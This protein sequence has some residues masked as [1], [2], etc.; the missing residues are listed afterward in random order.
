MF[1]IDEH[2]LPDWREDGYLYSHMIQDEQNTDGRPSSMPGCYLRA[3]AGAPSAL[4]G[5]LTGRPVPL[6]LQVPADADED[7]PVL[8][9]A[10]S[11][12]MEWGSVAEVPELQRRAIRIT[13]FSELDGEA[14]DSEA[15]GAGMW[16][17]QYLKSPLSSPKY[18]T[19]T[20]IALEDLH[21]PSLQAT[22]QHVPPSPN[23]SYID[24]AWRSDGSDASAGEEYD[25]YD[26]Y[27]DE[28]EQAYNEYNEGSSPAGHEHRHGYDE[29]QAR[30]SRMGDAE[31]AAPVA[32][33]P[34]DTDA[35]YHSEAHAGEFD[36]EEFDEYTL[37]A[38][39]AAAAQPPQPPS[40]T[41]PPPPS[42]DASSGSAPRSEDQHDAASTPQ[43]FQRSSGSA[44]A[45]ASQASSPRSADDMNQTYIGWQPQLS[46]PTAA[47]A[48]VVARMDSP[49]PAPA[50]TLVPESAASPVRS[51]SGGAASPAAWPDHKPSRPPPATPSDAV[52]LRAPGLVHR[53]LL[54]AASVAAEEQQPEPGPAATREHQPML[55]TEQR[56]YAASR[57][58][59]MQSLNDALAGV[60]AVQHRQ[61]PRSTPSSASGQ[62]DSPGYDEMFA[63][64]TGSME[65]AQQTQHSS[66]SASSAPEPAAA[67]VLAPSPKA[68]RPVP[69]QAA[70]QL[71]RLQ[72]S[73][74]GGPAR[75][76]LPAAQEASP[77]RPVL[78]SAVA[79]GTHI[80]PT[81]ARRGAKLEHADVYHDVPPVDPVEE[82][83][84]AAAPSQPSFKSAMPRPTLTTAGATAA[85]LLPRTRPA[86][87]TPR[88]VEQR[89]QG[90]QL[91]TSMQPGLP[92][93]GS[94]AAQV[95]DEPVERTSHPAWPSHDTQ[96]AVLP[97]RAAPGWPVDQP[98]PLAPEEELGRER[99]RHH[100]KSKKAKKAKK[101]K[102]HK[103]RSAS[104]EPSV[105]MPAYPGYPHG[106]PA[107]PGMWPGGYHPAVMMP[108][109]F[110]PGGMSMN[111]GMAPVAGPSKSYV[112]GADYGVNLSHAVP[113]GT[114]PDAP[115]PG[116]TMMAMSP[117]GTTMAPIQPMYDAQQGAWVYRAQG[118][119]APPAPAAAS[120]HSAAGAAAMVP[121]AP[122]ARTPEFH[123]GPHADFGSA[124]QG[125]SAFDSMT[126][127]YRAPEPA[128]APAPAQADGT[129][130][131]AYMQALHAGADAGAP[132][133]VDHQGT[134]GAGDET[135][136]DHQHG[137]A[138]SVPASA[139]APAAPAPVAHKP[140][141]ASTRQSLPRAQAA[142]WDRVPGA[143][144]EALLA[145]VRGWQCRSLFAS[146]KV[147]NI[148]R[149]LAD[150]QDMLDD[151]EPA[152]P[153]CAQLQAQLDS[154]AAALVA[155]VCFTSD[156]EMG[157]EWARW[158]ASSRQAKPSTGTRSAPPKKRQ[159]LKRGGG[160]A[161]GSRAAEY[162]KRVRQRNKAQV[163]ED[164]VADSASAKPDSRKSALPPKP[165]QTKRK[166]GQKQGDSVVAGTRQ[167]GSE[168]PP[169]PRWRVV[170]Q[171][172]K[173]EG[174][175][176]G[177]L[178]PG[179][180]AA[181]PGMVKDELS[182]AAAASASKDPSARDAFI[183]AYLAVTTWKP[184]QAGDDAAELLE[185]YGGS[186]SAA[187]ARVLGKKR[188][189][190]VVP[191]TRSP[192]FGE[193]FV[194]AVPS[195]LAD[196]AEDAVRAQR[197][198]PPL[199]DAVGTDAS[200]SRGL[201]SDFDWAGAA[202]RL[203]VLDSDRFVR[204]TFMGW[205]ALPLR[206]AMF[207]KPQ[208]SGAD[209]DDADV[210][211][212]P[213]FAK[214]GKM[215]LPLRGREGR[216]D[217]VAGQVLV[218][219]RMLPPDVQKLETAREAQRA[220]QAAR[221]A[222]VQPEAAEPAPSQPASRAT[223]A[224]R[225]KSAARGQPSFGAAA[226]KSTQRRPY[227]PPQFAKLD[228]SHVKPKTQSNSAA[229]ALSPK[230]AARARAAAGPPPRSEHK[231]RARAPADR[232]SM[233]ADGS[234]RRRPGPVGIPTRRASTGNTRVGAH[235]RPGPRSHL[236]AAFGSAQAEEYRPDARAEQDYWISAAGAMQGVM[237]VDEPSAA[238]LHT[239]RAPGAEAFRAPPPPPMPNNVDLS[240]QGW[241]GAD[242][243]AGQPSPHPASAEVIGDAELMAVLAGM[244]PPQPLSR[245]AIDAE[246]ARFAFDLKERIQ[247][248]SL[249][250]R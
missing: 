140:T 1:V 224:S 94:K 79:T 250:G 142:A 239:P 53:D 16:L 184:R 177:A 5:Y 204:D 119:R 117:G 86:L 216:A 113:A 168:L 2:W 87:D 195:G 138:W 179:V 98:A 75:P 124:S 42:A 160:G 178:A 64:L 44:S 233:G 230:Q 4:R 58:S 226:P 101:A 111:P 164:T 121:A 215:W 246:A 228:W 162:G 19:G 69:R 56:A 127:G 35:S 247:R 116:A 218:K 108:G 38:S 232:H 188:D 17:V 205:A 174:L 171:I 244:Q 112:V 156:A 198:M 208:S 81:P 146:P 165:W 166:P 211:D 13:Q 194:F 48:S 89:A 151:L 150:T 59:D 201:F 222:E 110:G 115:A 219:Y 9:H 185:L 236:A 10:I 159:P 123:S 103:R 114:M 167:L 128:P 182:A 153:L 243:L 157:E 70:A 34:E 155:A 231:P 170:V 27:D 91:A 176:A 135:Y 206:D 212:P 229:P 3:H 65:Y 131:L 163:S 49:S 109:M 221:A 189:T 11:V 82:P 122:E 105:H 147:A 242:V 183:T 139:P 57:V 199:A 214:Q 235:E 95:P 193:Q 134:A 41:P 100:Q 129:D 92:S 46:P 144:R 23:V 96:P 97:A 175:A 62:P 238:D 149:Q 136:A 120:G 14:S 141:A 223:S 225:A 21:M 227:K 210:I 126:S 72:L 7:Q 6:G 90:A 73:S 158:H 78:S 248:E 67:P 249:H 28:A 137:L 68:A 12:Y 50:R 169:A 207:G 83:A 61:S 180:R 88:E 20:G 161:L 107:Y 192:S 71:S 200:A 213:G 52:S 40:A 220:Q 55:S 33:G 172:V 26:E 148:K 77:P 191:G 104:P 173:A 29:E 132:A 187:I 186:D 99:R 240:Y 190:A 45:G 118:S 106:M 25:E 85:H 217:R 30:S 18:H 143:T 93:I 202:V 102:K 54:Q 130:L 43:S 234:Q 8:E 76:S 197:G 80:A 36:D 15:V 60:K 84:R 196:R 181:G 22:L 74:A 237:A 47:P 209:D 66:S 125:M 152:D 245:T 39:L 154:T 31:D 133:V 37:S 203:E 24:V 32:W 51:P 63:A 241:S 145:V